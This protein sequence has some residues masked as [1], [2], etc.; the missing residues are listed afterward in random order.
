MA[1]RDATLPI[2]DSSHDAEAGPSTF[3][4][5]VGQCHRPTEPLARILD[6]QEV[7]QITLGRGAVDADLRQGPRLNVTLADRWMSE[8]H[9]TVRCFAVGGG[10]LCV[11]EDRGST[12]GC[13]V[14]GA[15]VERH[16][17]HHGDIVETGQTFWTFYQQ[18][19]E[20]PATLLAAAYHGG[21]VTPSA[22]VS[23]L[24]LRNLLQL[25]RVGA[26]EIP[27]IVLGPSGA[28]K[29]LF[30]R[31]LH[32]ASGR[33]GELVVINCAA[34]PE[35]LVESELFGHRKGAF[36][37]AHEHKQG[38]VE[39]AHHGTLFLDEV[40]DLPLA[41]QAALLRLIQERSF[42][43]VG[44]TRVRSVD[45]R[46][47]AA[48]NR[49]LEQM[50]AD[51]QFRGDLFARLNGICLRLPPLRQRKE[52]IGLLLSVF[53]SR[54]GWTGE[55]SLGAYRALLAHPWPYNIRELEKVITTAVAL[56][57]GGP[58]IR[59][60]H[61]PATLRNDP[62]PANVP[63]GAGPDR[64]P[65]QRLEA[66]EGE[67]LLR[68]SDE[69]LRDRLMQLLVQHSGNV[70]ALARALETSRAQVHRLMKRAELSP[71]AFRRR[72]GSR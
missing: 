42:I 6:L 63:G 70:A 59:L 3:L 64:A 1:Q 12:N 39:A 58:R 40:G 20:D 65:A 41:G 36:T 29:E 27:V 25:Q 35:T 66:G 33:P 38:V 16:E 72:Q 55:L 32:R 15:A 67:R 21:A 14:N 19:E 13:R 7:E 31:T 57:Q 17:L 18:P 54:C 69:G 48:T 30:T 47:A 62:D 28:G 49:D 9:A 22:S 61:L 5:R 53:L 68:Y 24:V 44:E 43:R 4:I 50:V 45:V 60:S 56:A 52:D 34:I 51:E 10:Q 71:E 23:P 46:F 2:H 8:E 11:L 26:T 37:G